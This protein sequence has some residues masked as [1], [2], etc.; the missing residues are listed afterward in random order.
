MDDLQVPDSIG[1]QN[2][3]STIDTALDFITADGFTI[4]GLGDGAISFVD[5]LGVPVT[6]FL[7][8]PLVA[9]APAIAA[10]FALISPNELL[11]MLDQLGGWL[12]ALAQSEI[13]DMQVP[14]VGN[15]TVG[16]LLDYGEA[17]GEELLRFLVRHDGLSL[18]GDALDFGQLPAG[19]TLNFNIDVEI[20]SGTESFTVTLDPSLTGSFIGPGQLRQL[21]VTEVVNAIGDK[22]IS[23]E[24]EVF[25][26]GGRIGFRPVPGASLVQSVGLPMVGNETLRFDG[27]RLVV[28]EA[29]LDSGV[30][31]HDL[32]F[33]IN[34]DG[35]EKL[36][37][38]APDP[39]NTSVEHLISDINA[40]L[41]A[42]NLED[43]RVS[44]DAGSNRELAFSVV[45]GSDIGAAILVGIRNPSTLA[46]GLGLGLEVANFPSA[47][48]L[49]A[50]LSK[51]LSRLVP[52][53]TVTVDFADSEMSIKINFERKFEI[54]DL[55]ID[56]SVDLGEF[57]ELESSADLEVTA[58][59]GLTF[60]F[61]VDL[62][63][64]Q[65]LVVAPPVSVPSIPDNWELSGAA[66]FDVTLFQQNF[67]PEDRLSTDDDA[68]TEGVLDV[69][70]WSVG[71]NSGTP[72]TVVWT[73]P[74]DGQLLG[75]P[76][77]DPDAPPPPLRDQHFFIRVTD[78]VG[79][80]RLVEGV[81]LTAGTRQNNTV[82][83][84][85][86]DLEAAFN[87]A[88]DAISPDLRV[89]IDAAT[90]TETGFEIS[91]SG[92]GFD[93]YE[94]E[95]VTEEEFEVTR[96]AGVTV[97]PDDMNDSIS[98]LVADVQFAL[99]SAAQSAGLPRLDDTVLGL[100]EST[101]LAPDDAPV[102]GE[103]AVP[104]NGVLDRDV[105]FEVV[106]D[107][108][109]YRGMV[110][111]SD[112]ID[113]EQE[114]EQEMDP[115]AALAADVEL[116]IS[117]VVPA[118]AMSVVSVAA[119]LPMGDLAVDLT[120]T[121][122][123]V[124]TSSRVDPSGALDQDVAFTLTVGTTETTGSVAVQDT[125]DNVDASDL[126]SD[127]EAAINETLENAGLDTRIRV[128]A[129]SDNFLTFQH[130]AGAGVDIDFS[131]TLL[132]RLEYSVT[133]EAA[134]L[135]F[136]TPA[137]V[138]EFTGNRVA[139]YA[140]PVLVQPDDDSQGRL[141][142]RRIAVT[143]EFDNPA[144]T[145]L[146]LMSSPIPADG[147][148]DNNAVFTLIIDDTPYEITV[149]AAD[150]DTNSSVDHLID[151][152][153]AALNDALE[154]DF[155]ADS[156]QVRQFMF[157]DTMS[158]DGNRIEFFTDENSGID[159]I[160]LPAL[161]DDS[162]NSAINQLGFSTTDDYSARINSGDFFVEDVT[163]TGRLD[164]LADG[165]EA[166]AIVG[167]GGDGGLGLGV[168]VVESM[169]GVF[170]EVS[171]GLENPDWEEGDPDDEEFRI[172]LGTLWEYISG[173]ADQ[174]LT[175]LVDASVTGGVDID[176]NVAP[177]LPIRTPIEP[178]TVE[179]DLDIVD[180]LTE[181]RPVFTSIADSGIQV[182]VTG[183]D[184]NI[185]DALSNLT[186]SDVTGALLDVL[187]FLRE[188]QGDGDDSAL[189]EVLD[190]PL[191]L[192]NQSPTELLVIADD[193]ATLVDEVIANPAASLD[194]LES[195]LEDLLGLPKE[196][197]TLGLDFDDG[198][199]LRVDLVF[200]TGIEKSLGFDLD[201]EDLV[202][203][204]DPDS[205]ARTLLEGVTGLVGVSSTGDLS[206]G[207]DGTVRLSFGIELG[208]GNGSAELLGFE[209]D[210]T[211]TAGVLTGTRDAQAA[212]DRLVDQDIEFVLDLDGTEV[213]VLVTAGET[214]DMVEVDLA[215]PLS[216][217][218][219][220]PDLRPGNDITVTLRDGSS[221]DI[222]LNLIPL[223]D[224]TI[225]EVLFA[226]NN[227]SSDLD[228]VFSDELQR[229]L[230][231]DTSTV[232][233]TTQQTQSGVY[234]TQRDVLE[235]SALQFS[236]QVELDSIP[237][238]A[239]VPVFVEA[240]SD[241][242]RKHGWLRSTRRSARRWSMPGN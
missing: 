187:D 221:V 160:T 181:P 173:D 154:A 236:L 142:G 49:A 241:V 32:E 45:D 215:T 98:A 135:H 120:T 101:P 152:I 85:A 134:T 61:G 132:T 183:L 138:A 155:G 126:A 6:D 124:T 231:E 87:R 65:S 59:A 1:V 171:I 226:I 212:A 127:V 227:A 216:E 26:E 77:S 78:D 10:E 58:N 20:G 238:P 54:V 115:V 47:Q 153:N 143:A 172:S 189:A 220:A 67:E 128:T 112:T 196:L 2:I 242:T 200:N 147:Q 117:E 179:I 75:D 56:L 91:A 46:D 86:E 164:I 166:S 198:L 34:V 218:E 57:I 17:F 42:D 240:M 167:F 81:L 22:A 60:T 180:W 151:D 13:L 5:D 18:S 125:E 29:I 193:F 149:F 55:P 170:G 141:L 168:E 191:P 90:A 105:F 144:F 178:A 114:D 122:S 175:E 188:L 165:I 219:D 50:E 89:A 145:E 208:S 158:S 199:A 88:L 73:A 137:V 31:G 116:A 186:F 62:E 203:L 53:T 234:V 123:S 37:V 27:R 4:A 222:D 108:V 106:I 139:L 206:V 103:V 72:Q 210:A 202:G 185:Y 19:N 52:N 79:G 92:V 131:E 190:R 95:L 228:A 64:S 209:N 150:T 36:I 237:V 174:P 97:A 194:R 16:D 63:P 162:T 70:G 136:V 217:L 12:A 239:P 43:I 129:D 38:V 140:A 28:P 69:T 204:T 197:V 133:G 157:D 44:F 118:S 148:L 111:A 232:D 80:V 113:N 100:T 156:V 213:T 130:D 41:R 177:V 14:F 159:S 230:I 7:S 39:T 109:T 225:A 233:T 229:I 110:A 9:A 30:L 121:G 224:P 66:I 74:S 8:Q 24:I 15:T 40:Q 102:I 76:G 35:V 211:S 169:G 201:I 83:D 33:T 205:A 119:H 23:D 84:L 99:D 184:L 93:G 71:A 48:D 3:S 82:A 176:L 21:I 223:S 104:E 195:M 207:V 146:G 161:P 96:V 182:N 192:L 51:I 107:G 94:L 25:L 214:D 235:F 68:D 163:L 11:R